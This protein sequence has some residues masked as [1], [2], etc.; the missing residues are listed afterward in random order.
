VTWPSPTAEVIDIHERL[1][2]VAD[3]GNFDGPCVFVTLLQGIE[4]DPLE[5]WELAGTQ[6]LHLT[7]LDCLIDALTQKRD[8]L[9]ERLE[10]EARS[11]ET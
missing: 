11:A 4:E 8:E 7:E 1:K 5:T 3:L 6:N 10:R 2:L 9:K